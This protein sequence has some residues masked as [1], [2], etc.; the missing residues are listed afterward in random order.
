MYVNLKNIIFNRLIYILHVIE[1]LME[2]KKNVLIERS[3]ITTEYEKNWRED[4]IVFGGFDHLFKIFNE[5]SKKHLSSLTLADKN[6][7]SIILL[8]LKNYIMAIFSSS[9]S[10]LYRANNFISHSYLSLDFIGEYVKENDI[11]KNK[12]SKKNSSQIEE[13]FEL[14]KDIS[15]N[16]TNLNRKLSINTK[17]ELEKEK[18]QNNNNFEETV[19]FRQLVENLKGGL[20]VKIMEK[21]DCKELL[22]LLTNYILE[23]LNKMQNVEI[24][25]RIIIEHSLG[26]INSL[27][28]FDNNLLEFFFKENKQLSKEFILKG[29]FYQKNSNVRNFFCHA[30]YVLGLEA[31]TFHVNRSL[32]DIL[33]EQMPNSNDQTKAECNQYYELLCK[34]IE[35]LAFDNNPPNFTI[36]INTILDNIIMHKSIEKRNKNNT[37]KIL[38][39]LLKLSEKILTFSPDLRREIGQKQGNKFVNTIFHQC[40]F[41][42]QDKTEKFEDFYSKNEEDYEIDYIKCKS[43]ESRA[44]AYRL[45]SA[46]CYDSN[47]NLKVLLETGLIPLLSEKIPNLN[48]WNYISGSD[49]RSPY[50]YAGIK[51]L[52]CICYMNAMLQQ[53]FMNP[54]FRLFFF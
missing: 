52:G 51:N 44:A 10:N 2:E 42:I 29:L 28:L 1:Y 33:L 35:A 12:L 34:L 31:V 37:D 13:G 27:L 39:G 6:I 50:G 22:I 46:L 45:L 32:F 38:N 16:T 7:L 18:D 43:R 14:A 41:Q 24:E 47:E 17:T 54:T 40:L 11:N 25:E 15:D 21:L 8:I 26:I 36:L 4:F 9:V 3:E 53:F 23:T 30:L 19:E 5:F 49:I 20:G 48:T